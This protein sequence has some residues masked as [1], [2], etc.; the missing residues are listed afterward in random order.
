MLKDYYEMVWEPQWK[1][2]KRYWKGYLVFLTLYS[3]VVIGVAYFDNIKQYIQ[4]KINHKERE[5]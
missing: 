1:W 3:A 4:S 2:L 5:S